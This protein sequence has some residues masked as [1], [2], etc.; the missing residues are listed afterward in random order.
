MS[1]I[2]A[3]DFDAI[4]SEKKNRKHWLESTWSE[5]KNNNK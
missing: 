5:M 4:K 1:I 3:I 2:L